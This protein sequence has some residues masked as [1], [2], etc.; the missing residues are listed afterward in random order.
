[1]HQSTRFIDYN[2]MQNKRCDLYIFENELIDKIKKQHQLNVERNNL[3]A[4]IHVTSENNQILSLLK[5][6]I[7]ELKNIVINHLKSEYYDKKDI[8]LYD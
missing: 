7:A 1:M 2:R 6:E 5:N 8:E 3:A 4:C